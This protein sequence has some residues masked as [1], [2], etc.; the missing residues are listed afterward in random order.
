MTVFVKAAVQHEARTLPGRCYSSE[1]VFHAEKE[2]IFYHSWSCVG[3]EKQI[4]DLGDY[5]VATV[6]EEC[7]IILRDRGATAR[8]FYNVCRHRGTRLCTDVS[9]RFSGTIQ[10]PYHA[11]TYGLDGGL[12]AARHMQDVEGFDRHDYPLCS[13][14]LASWEGFLFL[15]LAQEPEPFEEAFAPLMWKFT[16]WQ[17]PTLRVAHRI[18]YDVQANW[19]LLVENYSECYHCPLIHP[20]LVQLS[21]ADSGRNDL[22]EG[23]FLGGY[24]TLNDQRGSLTMTGYTARPPIGDVAGEDLNRVYYYSIFPTMLLSLHPDYVMAHTLWPQGAR[25]TR[26]V[27]EWLFAP[28]TIAQPDFDPADAVEFWDMTNRQ[29]WHACEL[30]QLGVGSRAYTPGPYAHQEGLLDAFDQYYLKVMCET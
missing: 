17:M 12:L 19:K 26:I 27:C 10:C 2:R 28:E 13:A 1:E 14:A 24:N 16:A 29:D 30:T 11:W 4:P 25:Q 22:V 15:N 21:P 7:I 5:F 23:P 20:A 18:E 9:G 3:R 8:A 6:G